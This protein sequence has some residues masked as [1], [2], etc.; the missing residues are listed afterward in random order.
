MALI[1]QA[2][3]GW[4][5]FSY[6]AMGV[7][8]VLVAWIVHWLRRREPAWPPLRQALLAG[9]LPALV[10]VS[11]VV[12]LAQPLLDLQQRYEGFERDR[13]EVQYGSADFKHLF[14]RGVYRSGPADWIGRGEAAETRHLH[15]E[16]MALGPGGV[17][18]LL[19]AFGWWR[20]GFLQSYQRR[21]GRA[22]V[23]LALVG[24]VL[25]F[26]DSIGLPFTDRRLPLP[27]TALRETLP[28]FKAFRGVW[29]FSWLIVVATSWWSAVG[30]VQLVQLVREERR[31]VWLA[32]TALT[33]MALLGIPGAVPSLAIPFDQAPPGPPAAAGPVL[34]LPAPRN[35]YLEDRTEASW[36]MRAMEIGRPVTGGATGWVP[37]EI[38]ALRTGMF[39]CE[40]GAADAQ[41]LLRRMRSEGA[42]LAEIALRPGDEERIGFWRAQLMQF[43]AR[44]V[45][46]VPRAGYE[47][48]RLP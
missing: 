30:V 12:W 11:G 39:E 47:T 40:R 9:I 26:G 6:A 29:R 19:A 23:V 14:T 17:A 28:Y 21:M 2:A 1:A 7:L 37:P 46:T 45:Q 38:V 18:L 48:W 8:A 4:Y 32:P 15:G 16:R 22:L 24:L 25:A 34:T 27:L 31:H 42:V 44:R 10:A 5:G 3:W 43:G 33:L 35:E 13:K 41:A 36:L 20:R